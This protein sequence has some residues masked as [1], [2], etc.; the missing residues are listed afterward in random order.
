[1][2][3]LEVTNN[4]PVAMSFGIHPIVFAAIVGGIFAFIAGLIAIRCTSTAIRLLMS[5]LALL[6]LP[7]GLMIAGL[8]PWL[9][10]ARFRAYRSFYRDIE[11][12]MTRQQ[13]MEL[14]HRHYPTGGPRRTPNIVTDSPTNLG[15]F[16]NPEGSREPN[17]EG[18]F[19]TLTDGR[20][21]N[22]SYSAD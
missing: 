13:V 20:V 21:T 18:I 7:T 5:L 10:D 4:L 2:D 8:N 15:F 9:V 19:L 6:L 17:C 3:E 16:M 11:S 12:G 1:V 14:V 22:V